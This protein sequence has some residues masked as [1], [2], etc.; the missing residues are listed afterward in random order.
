MELE[1]DVYLNPFLETVYSWGHGR[2][3]WS[4]TGM[5]YRLSNGNDEVLR[6]PECEVP[7]GQLVIRGPEFTRAFEA[8][9]LPQCPWLF[10]E[11]GSLAL[12]TSLEY[13]K[14]IAKHRGKSTPLGRTIVSSDNRSSYFFTPS[15]RQ[16]VPIKPYA[17][18]EYP[19]PPDLTVVVDDGQ[20]SVSLYPDFWGSGAYVHSFRVVLGAIDD[21]DW[22]WANYFNS[23]LF[24]LDP[25]SRG[26]PLKASPILNFPGGVPRD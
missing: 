12:S 26:W 20:D 5:L 17:H 16:T 15:P 11:G 9:F 6:S 2:Y 19:I 13:L 25:R 21:Y 7:P 3:W 4:F 23:L 1:V 22:K 10:T 14:R 18:R 8:E 24:T